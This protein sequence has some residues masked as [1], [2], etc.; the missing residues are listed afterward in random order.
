L[1]G[2]SEQDDSGDKH[3]DPETEYAELRIVC[4]LLKLSASLEASGEATHTQRCARQS[5]Q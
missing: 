4:D 2:R 5:P 1:T 3:P